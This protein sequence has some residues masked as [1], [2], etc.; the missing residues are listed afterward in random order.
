MMSQITYLLIRLHHIFTYVNNFLIKI[1]NFIFN[2][3]INVQLNRSI[4]KK[5]KGVCAFEKRAHNTKEKKN[6]ILAI[7]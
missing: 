6:K 5:E 4:K 7:H 1:S 3:L 2:L